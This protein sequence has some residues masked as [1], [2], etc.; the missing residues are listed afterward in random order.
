MFGVG[1]VVYNPDYKRLEKSIKVLVKQDCEILI[2]DNTENCSH[3]LDSYK[4]I[5]NCYLKYNGENIG[6]AKAYNQIMEFYYEKGIKHVLTLDQDSICPDNLIEQYMQYI[7][8]PDIGILCPVLDYKGDQKSIEDGDFKYVD[9]CISSASLINVKCWKKCGGFDEQLFIDFVDFD[10]CY[11]I[12]EQGYKIGQIQKVHLDHELG[13]LEV[14]YLFGR[15]IMV[16]HHSPLRKYYYIRNAI[17]CHKKHSKMYPFKRLLKDIINN[18]L[19]AMLYESNKWK[20]L[21]LMNKG[22]IEGLTK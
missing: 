16:T 5:Y 6:V 13:K 15:K 20:R 1:I 18:Y 19:K 3:H 11:A 7:N 14:K 21:S 12:R 4:E 17:I 8:M 22:L 9:E 10:F 2:V